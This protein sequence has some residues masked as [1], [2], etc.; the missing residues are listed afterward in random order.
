MIGYELLAIR[1]RRPTKRYLVYDLYFHQCAVSIF[2]DIEAHNAK[3][4]KLLNVASQNPEVRTWKLLLPKAK[5][6]ESEFL[7]NIS[8]KEP[9]EYGELTDRK[10]PLVKVSG[11]VQL[12]KVYYLFP[13][14]SFSHC[15]DLITHMPL[16][17]FA[18]VE[19]NIIFLEEFEC[20]LCL[21]TEQQ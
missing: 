20:L 21:A 6:H 12:R 14:D 18:S 8:R 16:M 15:H 19:A 4:Q 3:Y 17:K 1:M 2:R 11:D 7:V 9:L 10:V 13:G 5:Y